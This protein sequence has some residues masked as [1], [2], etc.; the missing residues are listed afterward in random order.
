MSLQAVGLDIVRNLRRP[1]SGKPTPPPWLDSPEVLEAAAPSQMH[2]TRILGKLCF[3]CRTLNGTDDKFCLEC[4]SPLFRPSQ[5]RPVIP[6][7]ARPS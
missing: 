2:V 4:G 3:S 7:V 6:P 1:F 5:S